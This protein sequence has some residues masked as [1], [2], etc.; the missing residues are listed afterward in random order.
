MLDLG[1]FE[2]RWLPIK[3]IDGFE[4]SFQEVYCPIEDS[5]QMARDAPLSVMQWAAVWLADDGEKL[6]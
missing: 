5:A 6:V 4:A 3:D 2:F 1:T